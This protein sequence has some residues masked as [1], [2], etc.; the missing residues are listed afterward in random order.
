MVINSVSQLCIG[1]AFCKGLAPRIMTSRTL[2]NHLTHSWTI[3]PT[4]RSGP[5]TIYSKSKQSRL[6]KRSVDLIYIHARRL[7]QQYFICPNYSLWIVSIH[8]DKLKK[9]KYICFVFP[10]RVVED[11]KR[12]GYEVDRM[13]DLSQDLQDILNVSLKFS[14]LSMYHLNEP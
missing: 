8:D 10:Q 6:L 13:V 12:K 4:T 5:R 3:C 1:R 14:L 7:L 2:P 11:I 9:K